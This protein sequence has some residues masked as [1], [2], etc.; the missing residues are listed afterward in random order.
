MN[1]NKTD[2]E[3]TTNTTASSDDSSI[4]MGVC[5]FY[6]IIQIAVLTPGIVIGNTFMILAILVFF[7][8]HLHTNYLLFSRSCADL[9]VGLVT[10]P[11]FTAFYM[12]GPT[13]RL[14]SSR[15]A[16]L[17]WIASTLIG[18]GASILNSLVIVVDRYIAV[19]RPLQ[20]AQ[21]QKFC[22]VV[23]VLSVLWGFVI[24][25]TL[26]IILPNVDT[27]D[28]KTKCG[29]FTTLTNVH[30]PLLVFVFLASCLLGLTVM[31]L[32]ILFKI[33]R[34]RKRISSTS[35]V[36]HCKS[37]NKLEKDA[38][39]SELTVIYFFI[40]NLLWVPYLMAASLK[41]T[42]VSS[43]FA[44]LVRQGAL[45]LGFSSSMVSPLAY[46]II[47]N[48]FRIAYILL[49]VTPITRW[50]RIRYFDLVR[51][52]SSRRHSSKKRKILVA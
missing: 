5:T 30:A 3:F 19:C 2:S 36:L 7:R 35:L 26:I 17:T 44:D 50:S 46:A 31:Y 28:Q 21:V 43:K 1:I 6:A 41:F 45:L 37:F 14:H 13:G 34:Y 4:F 8:L 16:C 23:V 15:P 52:S 39:D 48:N 38:R 18:F 22:V 27:F 24:I 33:R 20:H 12:D 25:L 42:N 49:L 29:I 51:K 11:L 47:K 40:F 10:C 9:I 32:K